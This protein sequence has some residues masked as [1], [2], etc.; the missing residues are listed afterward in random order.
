MSIKLGRIAVLGVAA[1]ATVVSLSGGAVAAP[2][3]YAPLPLPANSVGPTQ[4][5]TAGVWG[6]DIHDNTIPWSK[7]GYDLRQHVTASDVTL[8]DAIKSS[9]QIKAG[10]I[11]ESDLNAALQT[12]VNGQDLHGDVTVIKEFPVTTINKI[13]G[14]WFDNKTSVGTFTLPAGGP[15]VIATSVKFTRTADG[16]AG[17]RPMVGLRIGQAAPSTWGDDA[18]SVGGNDIA[19]L[20]NAD[21]FG[22]D[23]KIVGPIDNSVVVDVDAHGYNDDQSAAGG[24]QIEAVVRVTVTH[25]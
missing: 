18:G 7:L 12:K 20:K 3:A 2:T 22:S 6:T 4:I 17:S 1:V 14:K 25:G 13:G 8:P 23:T 16:V 5:Q 15:W 24:G 9:T 19:P 11:Q 21:L 10:A